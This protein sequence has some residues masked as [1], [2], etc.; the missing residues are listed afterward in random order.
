M[1]KKT[2]PTAETE[3]PKTWHHFLLPATLLWIMWELASPQTLQPVAGHPISRDFVC[4]CGLHSFTPTRASVI[5][6]SQESKRL[7]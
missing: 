1:I 7:R 6:T 5:D 4:F 2:K 3:L